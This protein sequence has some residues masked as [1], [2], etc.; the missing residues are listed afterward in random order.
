M[1]PRKLIRAC[2]Y[3]HHNGGSHD[4]FAIVSKRS[5]RYQ[6]PITTNNLRQATIKSILKQAGLTVNEFVKVTL[7]GQLGT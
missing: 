2:F 6:C 4:T 3:T 1:S 7:G 5:C